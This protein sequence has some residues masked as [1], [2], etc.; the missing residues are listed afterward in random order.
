[1]NSDNK[2]LSTIIN[3]ISNNTIKQPIKL[4]RTLLKR[5]MPD[6]VSIE[7]PFYRKDEQSKRRIS[8]S[9]F[10]SSKQFLDKGSLIRQLKTSN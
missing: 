7:K 8:S 3:L 1:M 4:E 2:P 9:C 6:N 5:N 10:N